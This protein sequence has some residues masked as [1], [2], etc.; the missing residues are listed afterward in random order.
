MNNL[1]IY[2]ACRAVPQE[3]CK[4]FKK[5]GGFSGTDINPMWRIKKLTETFGPAG[6]GW[7]TEVTDMRHVEIDEDHVNTLV[8][9][10][11]YV[12][13]EGEW[14]KPIFGTGGNVAVTTYT[15][16][17]TGETRRSISDEGYKMAYTDALSVACKALGIGADVYWQSDRTKYSAPVEA[18]DATTASKPAPA[19]NPSSTTPNVLQRNLEA[20]K[21][22]A[23]E[24]K[25][26]G[27]DMAAVGQIAY[28]LDHANE[29]QID[30]CRRM[31]GGNLEKMTRKQ[32]GALIMKLQSAKQ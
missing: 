22:K 30:A 15:D 10:N 27:P 32:A 20:Q 16:K 31:Y 28:I 2:E 13:M 14:S 21:A 12:K 5:A 11:L 4:P 29:E 9:I 18:E 25:Q 3:A 17:T 7:Y 24:P 23:P 8:N 6:I 19:T 1:A 26:A